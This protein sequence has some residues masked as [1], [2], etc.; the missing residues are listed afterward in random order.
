MRI[1]NHKPR[2]LTLLF[3]VLTMKAIL[4]KQ[5]YSLTPVI[6]KSHRCTRC[7]SFL[8]A[9]LRCDMFLLIFWFYVCGEA[10]IKCYLVR[11]YW[12]ERR[13]LNRSNFAAHAKTMRMINSSTATGK[14]C[15]FSW[16]VSLMA[17]F[18]CAAKPTIKCDWRFLTFSDM[19]LFKQKDS[20]NLEG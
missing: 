1:I 6:L 9:L 5:S 10:Q 15:N 2:W 17:F 8:L 18:Y 4:A 11:L 14:M 13:H 7:F 16:N 20:I 3:Q 12:K 19:I